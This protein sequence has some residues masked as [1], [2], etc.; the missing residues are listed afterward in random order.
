MRAILLALLLLLALPVHTYAQGTPLSADEARDAV[1]KVIAVPP[2]IASR[3]VEPVGPGNP[4]WNLTFEGGTTALVDSVTGEIQQFSR[5]AN[6]ETGKGTVTEAQ[7]WN[8]AAALVNKAYPGRMATLRPSPV[9][10]P[11]KLD[12]GV[13]VTYTRLVNGVLYPANGVRVTVFNDGSVGALQTNWL[14]SV[15]FPPA[16]GLVSERTVL[17]KALATLTAN[18]Q[19]Y[20][21]YHHTKGVQS[22]P[23]LLYLVR[24]RGA[25]VPFYAATGE[26]VNPLPGEPAPGQPGWRPLLRWAPW[27]A[28]WAA[29]LALAFLAGRRRPVIQRKPAGKAAAKGVS[30]QHTA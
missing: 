9:R 27:A 10:T 20:L 17:D 8:T 16:T 21:I 23:E 6:A 5:L 24:T 1:N 18:P 2:L 13:T 15:D 19:A 7:A 12:Q 22:P 29:T 28:A 4:A 25:E 11:E 3:Q 14:A 26:F 30:D